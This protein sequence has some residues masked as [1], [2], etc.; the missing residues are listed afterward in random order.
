MVYRDSAE[1]LSKRHNTYCLLRRREK[2]ASFQRETETRPVSR[3]H[4]QGFL[5]TT[6]DPEAATAGRFQK[7]GRI[8]HKLAATGGPM[9][10]F[11]D[12]FARPTSLEAWVLDFL[13]VITDVVCEEK[14]PRMK[15]HT[16]T[17]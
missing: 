1:A 10:C 3:R 6:S 12:D 13:R 11:R 8:T 14:V 17:R 16:E 15:P 5:C 7:A 2:A 9:V 4:E